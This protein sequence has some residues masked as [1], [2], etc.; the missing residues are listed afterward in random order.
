MAEP[1]GACTAS[2]TIFDTF[3]HVCCCCNHSNAGAAAL[4]L[5]LLPLR[6]SL[7]FVAIWSKDPA[8]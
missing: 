6:L 7:Q 3:Q 8:S 5:L 1:A 2:K 4:Q